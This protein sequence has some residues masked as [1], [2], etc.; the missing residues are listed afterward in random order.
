MRPLLHLGHQRYLVHGVEVLLAGDEH[1]AY[2][3]LG[4]PVEA[5]T[6]SLE[7]GEI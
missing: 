7:L 4:A 1:L 2:V 3:G 5:R 6:L